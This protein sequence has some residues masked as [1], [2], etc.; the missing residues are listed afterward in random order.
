MPRT[1]IPLP[2]GFYT[3]ESLPFSA[4]RCVNWIPTMAEGGALN[5]RALLQVP[6]IKQFSD[7][8]VSV[9]RGSWK[10][11]GVPYFVNGNSLLSTSST[12]SVT[13][14][15]A[16]EGDGRVSMADNGQ[17]LVVLVPGAKAY[18]YDNIADELTEITDGDFIQSD[19][20]VYKDGYF[21]FTASDGSVFFN[22]SL[23]D[24]FSFDALDFGTA[25]IS[26]DKIVAAHVNHN[27]LFILGTETI[28]IFQNVGG[29]GFPFQRI[30]GANIQKGAHSKFSIVEFDNTFCF[31]GGGLNERSAIWKVS[32][33]SSVQKIS[34]DAIDKEIQKFT[35][36]EI[37]NSFAMTYSLNGQFFAIFTFESERIPSRTFV[38]NATSSAFSGVKVWFELQSGVK[39]NRWQVQSIVAAYGKL[40]V[41]DYFTGLIGEIDKDTLTYY[42]ELIS[43]S[44][45]TQPFS[46]NGLPVFAGILEA[47]FE[48]GTGLTGDIGTEFV[49]NVG[50]VPGE[51]WN[52]VVRMDF[53]DDGGRTFS[54]EFSR[55]IGKI[56][57][58]EQRS[59]W[60]RQGRFPVSRT[61]RITVTDPIRANLLKL[62]ATPELG[63]Q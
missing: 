53:S 34:T 63:V 44:M 8:A 38:Y 31:V 23:N 50:T 19:T 14:H 33:A 32:G 21:V 42:D 41:G 13:N 7:T 27:E 17:Y 40:L 49:Y 24:P 37:S 16:I 46:Q 12:G 58:Y 10:M 3:S 20:V 47:T 22:S 51:A 48:S 4:Q 62:A 52:P 45:S 11:S 25:E 6:G 55:S 5:D 57:K 35:R 39:D 30:P 61:I 1:A 15:G 26:P 18:A 9:N 59:V 43:R 29:T 60:N 28:E 56:G 2:L 36:D 54:S